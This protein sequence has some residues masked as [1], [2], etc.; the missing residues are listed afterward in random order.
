MYI[1]INIAHKHL[2]FTTFRSLDPTTQIET[3]AF[4]SRNFRKYRFATKAMINIINEM[5][6][7]ER[8][9]GIAIA[10]AGELDPASG[11]ILGSYSFD[12]W[13]GND[14]QHDLAKFSCPVV[15]ENDAIVAAVGQYIFNDQQG[16]RLGCI[17]FAR[18]GGIGAAVVN[19][20][21]NDLLTYPIEFGHL[22]IVP[23][24][25]R[26]DCG[27]RGCLEQYVSGK[28]IVETYDIAQEDLR[29]DE[30]MITTARYLAQGIMTLLI[31]YPV[32]QLVI[33][34]EDPQLQRSFLRGLANWSGKMLER[35]F[36][37]NQPSIVVSATEDAINTG[38]LALLKSKNKIINMRFERKGS[39]SSV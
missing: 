8:V 10:F 24:G 19:K 4:P 17:Y 22:V 9:E 23:D 27:Q 25:K 36:M 15:V 3:K 30:I 11:N 34:G 5:R 37:F 2:R 1:S 35:K 28:S 26:C 16:S 14:L 39:Q 12:S 32:D 20:V 21:G 33:T 38:N 7:T 31:F 18:D 29:D 6:D 13:G